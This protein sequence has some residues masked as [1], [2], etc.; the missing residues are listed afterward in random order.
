M[1]LCA[2]E[3]MGKTPLNHW[4]PW[5]PL[6]IQKPEHKFHYV[7]SISISSI[8][9]QKPE[10]SFPTQSGPSDNFWT[11]LTKL[12]LCGIVPDPWSIL[13]NSP[14]PLAHSDPM[15]CKIYLI[16]ASD[17]STLPPMTPSSP[18]WACVEF[19]QIP[20]LYLWIPHPLWPTL[21]QCRARFIWWVRLTFQLY[22]LW[23]PHA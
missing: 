16:A 15:S 4:T 17:I 18:I 19:Y 20:G 11:P 23:P 10:P 1:G 12:S 21:I 14:P 13:M 9:R 22:P 8:F 5:P 2:R 6:G 3:N 7:A